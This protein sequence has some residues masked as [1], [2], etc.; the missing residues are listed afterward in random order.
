M[1]TAIA[2]T[3]DDARDGAGSGFRRFWIAQTI[4]LAGGQV[5]ELAIPVTA[6]LV[7]AATPAQMGVLEAVATAPLL[8]F[9]LLAGGVLDRTRRRPFL[10]WTGVGR[11]LVLAAIPAAFWLGSVRIELLYV[12]GFVVGS[13]TVFA[14]VAQAAILPV[15]VGRRRLVEANSRLSLSDSVTSVVGPGIGGLAI[16]LFT[17]PVAIL[18]DSVAFAIAAALTAT[19]RVDESS[20]P[21]AEPHSPLWRSIIG[22]LGFVAREPVLRAL[23]GSAGTFQLFYGGLLAMYVIFVI[24]DLALSPAILGLIYAV[25]SFGPIAAALIVGPAVR[26]LGAGR[27]IQISGLLAA[28]ANLLV[29]VA[30][31]AVWWVLALLVAGRG[32]VGLGAVVSGI[33]RSSIRQGLTPHELQGRVA[34]TM[35]LIEWGPLPIGSLLGGLLATQ[36]GV[37]PALYVAAAGTLLSLPWLLAAG[38]RRLK[39]LPVA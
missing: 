12:I 3:I 22:G 5:S 2:D 18:A 31:G 23:A 7:L 29:P 16:Q 36:I 24:R 10:I 8:L 15:L 4:S 38:L 9:G 11:A 32:L 13:L 33:A 27:A 37:R 30:G 20:G 17:A 19:V 21:V 6:A 14:D 35:R 28:A 39:E 34:A 25:A 1:L 26:R